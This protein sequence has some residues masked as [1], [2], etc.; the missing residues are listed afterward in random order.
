MGDYS[1]VMHEEALV[2]RILSRAIYGPKYPYGST[3]DVIYSSE[4][5]GDG[6]GVVS[7]LIVYPQPDAA[8]WKTGKAVSND[9]IPVLK[10]E[11]I[12]KQRNPHAFPQMS[13]LLLQRSYY[14]LIEKLRVQMVETMATMEKTE[15]AEKLKKDDISTEK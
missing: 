6:D 2:A 1:P 12:V 14:N 4:S 10:S 5:M 13:P 11:R 8:V 7:W 3:F 15:E 9:W